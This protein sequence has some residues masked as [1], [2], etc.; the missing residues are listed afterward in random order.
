VIYLNSCEFSYE[1]WRR[2]LDFSQTRSCTLPSLTPL[3][4]VFGPATQSQ[5]LVTYS[6]WPHRLLVRSGCD[7]AVQG[8]R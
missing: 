8:I 4:P 5:T 2:I 3:N 7:R 6:L 1:F